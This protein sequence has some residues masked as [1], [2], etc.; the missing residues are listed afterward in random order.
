MTHMLHHAWMN[1]EALGLR[2]GVNPEIFAILYALH[3]AFLWPTAGIILMRLRMGQDVTNLV[4]FW[5]IVLISPWFY[6][7]FF[8]HLPRLADA[9]LIAAMAFIAWHGYQKMQGRMAAE[10]GNRK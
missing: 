3:Y 8:G 6:P 5:V 1:F 10:V 7:L 9:G 2:Y 4:T